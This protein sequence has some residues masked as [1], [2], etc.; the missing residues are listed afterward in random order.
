MQSIERFVVDQ[1]TAW[2]VLGCAVAAVQDGQV[3]LAAGWGQADLDTKLPVTGDTLFAIGS[4]TKAFT[5][6]TVSVSWAG[7]DP[8]PAWLD[9]ARELSEYWIHRQQI[10]QALASRAAW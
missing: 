6:A 2:E 1:L 4:T 10:L 5:A 8:V 7:P 3:V 9:Q